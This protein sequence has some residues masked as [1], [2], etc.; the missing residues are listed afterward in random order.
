MAAARSVLTSLPQGQSSLAGLVGRMRQ[1]QLGGPAMAED[2]VECLVG[3]CLSS[4][5]R[6]AALMG[7]GRTFLR[8]FLNGVYRA[9]HALLGT[10]VSTSVSTRLVAAP[11]APREPSAFAPP[12]KPDSPSAPPATPEETTPPPPLP[13][14]GAEEFR[15]PESCVTASNPPQQLGM[16]RLLNGSVGA[17]PQ[18][19]T[20]VPHPLV[21]N[22]DPQPSFRKQR[23][24]LRNARVPRGGDVVELR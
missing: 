6:L 14:L 12:S 15:L 22:R 11:A 24:P 8:E 10:A 1:E 21:R 9:A 20:V 16:D 18:Q 7:S 17:A 5:E 3:F 4:A 2:Q 23:N 19:M 13:D